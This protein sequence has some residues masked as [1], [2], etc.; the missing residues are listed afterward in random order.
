MINDI[1]NL[2]S[3]TL[4][5]KRALAK[6]LLSQKGTK[7]SPASSVADSASVTQDIPEAFYNFE[8]FPGYLALLQQGRVMEEN[9]IRNPYFNCHE[10]VSNN[11]LRIDGKEYI[12]YSGYNYLGLSGDKDVEQAAIDAIQQYGTSVSASRIAS[13]EIS[14]HR[15]LELELA[16]MMDT[17]DCSVYVSGYGTNV[18][19]IGYLFNAKDLI[20]HDNLTHN[21]AIT[22]AILSGAR[23]IPFRH[24]DWTHLEELL[25]AN[26]NQHERV[27]IIIEGAYSMDG[28]IPDL[29]PLLEIKKKHKALLMI[30]E[31]HSAG[32][33]G[34][35]GFGIGEHFGIKGSEVDI[36]MGTLS[37]SFASCGGF[38]AGSK[39]LI[40]NLRYNA[41]GGFLYSAG[42]TP[43]NTAAALAAVRKMKAEPQRVQ[44]LQSRAKLFLDIAKK[45]NLDT[46]PSHGTP[47]IPVIIGNSLLSLQLGQAL[48]A[49]GINVQP[50]LYPAV[51]ENEARLRFFI[52]AD[53]TDE[54]IRFTVDTIK[55]QLSKLTQ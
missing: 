15:E 55:E 6:S 39:A 1:N 35:R 50:M 11:T 54:Q 20:L 24:N 28:D 51:A 8:K 25:Q 9:D 31:A 46:G 12:N 22:G 33:I 30:D 42:I 29:L 40:Q 14:L 23:R 3:M 16:A 32:T 27:L 47:I 13:G 18:S 5:Q 38:I 21:S 37:K 10:D 43:P 52:T 53:H 2:S 48:Y 4:E 36:W 49:A 26:R 34:P 17:E 7:K 41:P 44:H 45:H 19:T